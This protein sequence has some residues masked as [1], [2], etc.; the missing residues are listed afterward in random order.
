[1]SFATF[2]ARR[3]FTGR[4]RL[5]ASFLS[6]I[7]IFGVAVGV[8]SLI[9]VMSVMTGFGKNLQQKLIG[10][11]AH[12]VVEG[13]DDNA[14]VFDKD[15]ES[16]AVMITGEGIVEIPDS[17]G[18]YAFGVNIR[19][20][21][22]TDL[23]KLNGVEWFGS[24]LS[25]GAVILGSELAYQM[26]VSPDFGDSVNLVVPLGH[27]GPTGEFAP[28]RKSFAVGGVF[29]SGYFENDSKLVIITRADARKLLGD[30]AVT[31]LNIWLKNNRRAAEFSSK[32]RELFPQFKVLSWS[33]TN[34]KLFAALKLERTAMTILLL[35]IVIV[36]SISI[37]SVIF[38]YVFAR[39]KDIAILS[40]IGAEDAQIRKIFIKIGAYIGFI[41]TAIGLLSSLVVCTLLYYKRIELPSSYYLDHLPIAISWPFVAI[42]TATSIMIAVL[43]SIY[44]ANQISSIKS[45]T[46][47]RYE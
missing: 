43:A 19:G 22:E 8:F 18:K 15:I 11:N 34:K 26:G 12:I 45:Q 7:A 23:G 13:A 4:K 14:K 17:D 38:I 5:F 24:G 41:G 31:S 42:V 3:Y 47:L 37:V 28:T 33:E 2:M 40:A 20:I 27:I 25:D 10:F 36:A 9:V 32:M 16:S 39:R 46:T 35:L 29:K 1:M 44:P 21:D 30:N 6:A